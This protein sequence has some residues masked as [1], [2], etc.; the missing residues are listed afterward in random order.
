INTM[1]R[2]VSAGK[3]ASR[4][5]NTSN[6]PAEAP[7][8]T[9]GMTAQSAQ[10][11]AAPAVKARRPPDFVLG[12]TT[13]GT[14]FSC[15]NAAVSTRRQWQVRAIRGYRATASILLQ[16]TLQVSSFVDHL[17]E[18]AGVCDTKVDGI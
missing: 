1:A 2:P 4:S 11:S 8:P 10:A 6:P 12:R 18:P 5:L 16:G 14:R 9:T 15:M 13:P 3:S 17:V 7:M